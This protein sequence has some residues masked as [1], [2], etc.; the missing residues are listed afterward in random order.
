MMTGKSQ[1]KSY[2]QN[3]ARFILHWTQTGSNIV[4]DAHTR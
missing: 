1:L 2:G 4:H 3:P